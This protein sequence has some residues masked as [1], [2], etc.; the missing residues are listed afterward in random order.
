MITRKMT[1]EVS[2]DSSSSQKREE[3]QVL[4]RFGT[5]LKLMVWARAAW[6]VRAARRLLAHA[7]LCEDTPDRCAEDLSRSGQYRRF[8][9]S[10]V[11]AE[12]P[13]VPACRASLI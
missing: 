6:D 11:A 12:S 3:Q 5:A 10:A 13:V 9:E 1:P 7:A 2:L 8:G 4:H